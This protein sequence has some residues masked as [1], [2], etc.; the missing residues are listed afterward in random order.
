MPEHVHLLVYPTVMPLEIDHLLSAMK[1]P[2]SARIKRLLGEA[3]SPL[4]E[5]LTVLERP[6]KTAFR[7]WQEGPGYDRNLSSEKVVMSAIDYI[8]DNPVRRGLTREAVQWKWSS[9]RW[10]ASER[11][12]IDPHLAEVH[13]LPPEFFS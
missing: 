13:G 3:E 12:V 8:H 2:C 7:Y 4:L 1:Q 9:A 10:S 11:R 5:R 6:G